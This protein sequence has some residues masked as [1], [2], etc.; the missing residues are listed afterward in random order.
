[1]RTTSIDLESMEAFIDRLIAGFAISPREEASLTVLRALY[2][3]ALFPKIKRTDVLRR[4]LAAAA[5]FLKDDYAALPS[6]CQRRVETALI[7]LQSGRTKFDAAD[8][9]KAIAH[10]LNSKKRSP[11]VYIAKLITNYASE[12]ALIW[13][14]RGLRVGRGVHPLKSDYRSEFH[15]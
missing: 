5:D 14:G 1:V 8:V 13:R 11:Q 12:V 10:S 15:R 3:R 9:C 6:D 2:P 4:R 7:K